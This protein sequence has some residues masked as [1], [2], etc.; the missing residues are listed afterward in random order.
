MSRIVASLIQ[1]I[2][3]SQVSTEDI[4][5]YIEPYDIFDEDEYFE[6]M[7]QKHDETAIHRTASKIANRNITFGFCNYPNEVSIEAER[8]LTKTGSRQGV[9]VLSA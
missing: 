3:I 8:S 5:R 6:L 7:R 1:M 4:I 9:V 2:N